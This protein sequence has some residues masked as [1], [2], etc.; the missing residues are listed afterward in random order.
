MKTIKKFA[1]RLPLYRLV[2]RSIFSGHDR[3]TIKALIAFAD[4]QTDWAQKKGA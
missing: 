4:E 1:S 3:L 2:L